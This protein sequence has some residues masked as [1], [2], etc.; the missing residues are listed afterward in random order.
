MLRGNVPL[1]LR[2]EA[3]MF[4]EQIRRFRLLAVGSA[5]ASLAL[6]VGQPATAA[7]VGE[8]LT[9]S[10]DTQ[11]W[12]NALSGDA[13]ITGTV[14]C[15]VID[16]G[17]EIYVEVRQDD[18]SYGYGETALQC[19]APE[20]RW[21][22]DIDGDEFSSGPAALEGTASYEVETED[23]ERSDT[24][25]L[26]A[27]TRIGTM[28]DDDFTGTQ[29]KDQICGL[30][31]DDEFNGRGGNDVLRGGDGDDIAKGSEGNDVMFGGYGEDRL[32]GGFGDD[33]LSGNQQRDF[34]NGEQGNDS[35]DGGPGKDT[36]QSC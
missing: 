2:K 15:P 20:V 33:K 11:T 30:D 9:L 23:A 13:V 21:L 35:C 26:V 5:L 31:G 12:V 3:A 10:F 25:N 34:L 4:H 24:T 22:I 36:E 18:S 28:E 6:I 17:V 1:S 7:P 14:D 19:D 27:C 8:G 29:K 16:Q 32:L